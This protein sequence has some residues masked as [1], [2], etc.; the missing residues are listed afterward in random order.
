MVWTVNDLLPLKLEEPVRFE[1]T[2]VLLADA[3]TLYIRMG[4]KYASAETDMF[5]RIMLTE[6]REQGVKPK[7][8]RYQML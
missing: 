2:A 6:V 4:L 8:I 1:I 3:M 5:G 7:T